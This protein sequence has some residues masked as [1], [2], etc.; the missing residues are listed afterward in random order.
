M[1]NIMIIIYFSFVY[2]LELKK[3]K[4]NTYFLWKL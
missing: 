4:L 1:T 3:K 2:V